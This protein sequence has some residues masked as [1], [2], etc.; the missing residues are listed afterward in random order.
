MERSSDEV[1]ADWMHRR[2]APV[3][4]WADRHPVA[5]DVLSAAALALA[6]FVGIAV[7]G[8]LHHPDVIVFCFALPAPLLL[9][10]RDPRLSFG[11]IALIALAQWI[12]STPQLSDGAVLISMFWLMLDGEL[13]EM[14]IAAAIVEA[15]AVMAAL[16]WAPDQ[17]AK[18]WVGITGLGVAAGGLGVSIRQRRALIA[19]LRERAARLEFE[20]D[21]EGRLAA[22][23]ERA[24]IAREMHDIVSHNL[25][26]MIGL[27]DGASYA[28]G[29][30]PDTSLSAME[31]VSQTG[32]QALGEMRRL[33]GVLRDEPEAGGEDAYQPQPGLDRLDDL[34]ARV[35]AAGIPV[36]IEVFGDPHALPGGVQ[37][38]VFRVA[39]EALTNTL[40]HARRPATARLTLR[41]EPDQVVLEVS[42]TGSGAP[43][44]TEPAALDDAPPA[45]P[46]LPSGGRGIHGMRERAAAYGG[47]LVAGPRPE[48][49]W[50]V[51]L[52]IAPETAAVH[53]PGEAR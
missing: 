43:D 36:A 40:K 39:Q 3:T 38:T 17:P 44:D 35:E 48:G 41:C 24:R 19:S 2:V 8:R 47:D 1:I 50:R 12:T 13:T 20:R 14:A 25:T 27:A 21:Q 22:A 29:A 11:L 26:V 10:H 30:S 31:R 6:S 23:A 42:D 7:Q 46:A 34:L 51:V 49:G 32:R 53:G 28:L 33:L 18:V 16:R 45:A 9:R 4:R 52:T 5:L 15:G 37:L